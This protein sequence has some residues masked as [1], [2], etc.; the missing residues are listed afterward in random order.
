M[1]SLIL[2][3][4]S[5]E[6]LAEEA[7]SIAARLLCR[8]HENPSR[9]PDCRRVIG[10]S[11]PDF[12][13]VEPE[14]VQIKVERVREALRFAV[15]RPYEAPRRVAW[16]D[17]ADRLGEA[18]ANALLKSLEEPGERMTWL[19]TT[20][21]PDHLLPTIRSRCEIRRLAPPPPERLS[22]DLRGAGCPEG[23]LADAIAFGL[24]PSRL[25]SIE[26]LRAR[27]RLILAAL[28]QGSL[29]SILSLCA[30]GE[31]ESW[32]M[33]LSSLL[34]DAALVSSGVALDRI[35][36]AGAAAEVRR[37]A[38]S[39][40]AAALARA[41]ARAAEIPAE[42]DRYRQK[43]LVFESVLLALFQEGEERT[44]GGK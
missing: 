22:A 5:P 10:N 36:H 9:C 31:D 13:R 8:G 6:R 4:A 7:A 29:S 17:S 40:P 2:T 33:L 38:S 21:R 35:R 20:T 37:V 24:E 34:R 18:A 28:S 25:G 41:A 32:A 14:G 26:E 42:L 23:D 44:F 19:L 43:R 15:G 39:F 27:R 1:P 11:H 16:I 30:L 3:G 12:F